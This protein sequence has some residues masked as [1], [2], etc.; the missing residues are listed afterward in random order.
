MFSEEQSAKGDE[1]GVRGRARQRIKLEDMAVQE[2][3]RA[4][5]PAGRVLLEIWNKRRIAAL[6][7]PR[8]P[9]AA[10]KR[11]GRLIRWTMGME[12]A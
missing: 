4:G 5:L 11:G 9:Q 12:Q 7:R 1:S 6:V 2:C 8:D 10:S 3:E